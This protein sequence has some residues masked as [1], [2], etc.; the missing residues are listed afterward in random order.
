MTNTSSAP[1]NAVQ[2][3]SNIP[4]PE[5]SVTARLYPFLETLEV[6]QCAM[7]QNR[8]FYTKAY[9]AASS[10]GK[11]TQKSFA[12]RILSDGFGLWRIK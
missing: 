4:L 11:R 9:T 2:I 5:R 7:I 1:S 8:E 3:V 10:Y 12:G 6:G